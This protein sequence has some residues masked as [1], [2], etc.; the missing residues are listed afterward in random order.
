L[1]LE[2]LKLKKPKLDKHFIKKPSYP[3]GPKALWAFIRRHLRYPKEAM[4]NN[5]AGIVRIRYTINNKGKVIDTQI[6]H[7]LGHGCDEEA[8]RV[9]RMLKYHVPKHR[10]VKV[11]YHRTLNVRFKPPKKKTLKVT[12]SKSKPEK[13]KKEA[14]KKKSGYGYT[15]TIN[16]P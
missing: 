2:C 6:L 13:K 16:K 5:I 14:K 8:D 7:S 12:V 10:K 15:I 11:K 4:E 9:I 3:G 1:Y